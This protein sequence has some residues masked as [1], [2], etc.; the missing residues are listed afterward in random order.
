MIL[1]NNHI[2][3]HL[4]EIRVMIYNINDGIKEPTRS[5]QNCNISHT[6]IDTWWVSKMEESLY[7]Q[8]IIWV[9]NILIPYLH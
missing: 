8:V 4:L 1:R 6:Y 2:I 7:T 3:A 9:D 5:F